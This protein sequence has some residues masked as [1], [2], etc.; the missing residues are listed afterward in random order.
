MKYLSYIAFTLILISCE[1]QI[2]PKLEDAPDVLVIDAFL[3]DIDS[4]QSIRITRSRP[5]FENLLAE[6]V[7]G[8]TVEV[9]SSNGN[10]LTF[11]EA[12]GGVYQWD[13]LTNGPIGT[14]GDSLTLQVQIGNAS[15]EAGSEIRR[16]PDIDS[17]T[18]RFEKED[19]IFPDSY[20]AEFWSRD[21]LGPGDTYW[22]KSYK[23]GVFLNQPNEINIAFDAGFSEGGNVDGLIFIPPIRDIINPF[24]EDDNDGFLS[25]FEDGDSVYVEIHS[26]TEEAFEFLNDVRIQTDRPGGFAELFATPLANISSNINY[27]GDDPNVVVTGFF[28]VSSVKGK[29]KRLDISQVPKGN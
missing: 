12:S 15:F 4:V 11:S 28:S 13:P 26:I 25:P 10:T 29:G 19:F 24:E 3:N 18:F 20:F 1:D 6:G 5:Y 22:I 21:P 17:V 16:V 8:A 7:E 9:L 2:T 27:L 23:N 14:V